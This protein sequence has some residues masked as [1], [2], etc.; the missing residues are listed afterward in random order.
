MGGFLGFKKSFSRPD[1][2]KT[3]NSVKPNLADP[4]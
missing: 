3:N 4:G 2:S 1:N